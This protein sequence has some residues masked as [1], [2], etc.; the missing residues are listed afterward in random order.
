MVIINNCIVNSDKYLI[1]TKK[2]NCNI[3]CAMF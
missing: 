3:M 2:S 1:F